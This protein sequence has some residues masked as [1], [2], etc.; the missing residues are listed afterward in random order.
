MGSAASRGTHDRS[1]EKVDHSKLLERKGNDTVLIEAQPNA[2]DRQ[3]VPTLE[4]SCNGEVAQKLPLD[5]SRILIGRAD[6]NDVSIP[7]HYVSRHH[8]L[9]IRHRDSTIL[10]DLNS[11]N[12]TFINARPVQY[13]ELEDGDEITVDRHSMF[14]E[15]SIRFINPLKTTRGRFRDTKAF[16]AFIKKALAETARLLG[17]SDTDLLPRLSENVPTEIGIIDDR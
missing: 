12:G 15:Y 16:E 2:E 4:V 5:S 13:E 11:T 8:I 3:D 10:V 6:D 17:K 7:S 1:V 14:V 9:L